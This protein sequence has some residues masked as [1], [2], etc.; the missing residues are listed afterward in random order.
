MKSRF[1]FA[2]AAEIVGKLLVASLFWFSGIFDMALNWPAVARTVASQ[3]LPTPVFLG[4]GAMV[5]EIVGPALLF[6][7][8]F[9]RIAWGMLSLYC[10]LTALLF[11]QFW[12][13]SGFERTGAS[14]HF[15]KNLAM[16]GAF[17]LLSLP[18]PT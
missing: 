6:I 18:R 1:S 4:A 13:L 14:F 12:Y 10:M 8:R 15:F 9:E 16:C 11:H 17:T 2:S 3:G 5:L 7:P